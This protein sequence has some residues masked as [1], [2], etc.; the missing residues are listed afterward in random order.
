VAWYEEMDGTYVYPTIIAI[1][2]DWHGTPLA[3]AILEWAMARARQISAGHPPEAEKFYQG[4][5]AETQTARL[6]MLERYG[7]EPARYWFE[8]YRDLSQPIP[9]AVMPEGLEVRPVLPEHYRLISEAADEAFR[10][11]W[12]HVDDTEEDFQRWVGKIEKGL[13]GYKPEY[14]MVAWDGDQVAGMVLNSIFD[15]ENQILGV[16]RGW[17]DPICVRRPWRKRGLAT[18]LINKSLALLKELGMDEGALGVDTINPSGALKLY[19][20]CGFVNH[21]KWVTYRKPF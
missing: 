18:A 4:G 16:K 5:G 11:H 8:M 6:A 21:Q 14:W 12:G 9:E 2:P 3:E 19:E 20:N 10:D 7:Y 17:T 1:H 15:G 13:D